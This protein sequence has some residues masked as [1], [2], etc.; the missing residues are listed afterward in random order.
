MKLLRCLLLLVLIAPVAQARDEP[1]EFVARVAKKLYELHEQHKQTDGPDP[2]FPVAC[3]KIIEDAT[4]ELRI[5]LTDPAWRRTLTVPTREGATL[6]QIAALAGIVEWVDLLLAQPE[7]WPDLE[8]PIEEYGTV[9]SMA[10]V[11][12][13]L[14]WRVCGDDEGMALGAD[15][16]RGYYANLPD[17]MPYRQIRQL[18]EDAGATPRPDL[19]RQAWLTQC[20]PGQEKI[21]GV[22][23]RI[24]NAPDIL[25]ALLGELA[26]LPST[27]SD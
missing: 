17:G 26:L 21:P 13:M 22:R 23:V 11:P 4:A 27:P 18:L 8:R 16:M 9:W 25:S 14:F 10:S 7:I 24:A 12:P 19:A 6:L 2:A 3:R 20:Q 15:I 1:I 5:L